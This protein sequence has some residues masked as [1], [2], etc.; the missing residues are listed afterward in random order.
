MAKVLREERQFGLSPIRVSTGNSSDGSLIGRSLASAGNDLA[1]MFFRDAARVAASKGEEGGLSQFAQ[2]IVTIDPDT[3]EPVAYEPPE[4]AGT[5]YTEAYQKVV[6]NRFYK[7][8]DDE[9]KARADELIKKTGGDPAKFN[10]AMSSYVGEMTNVATGP[11]RAYIDEVGKNYN[12]EITKTLV[13]RRIAAERAALKESGKESIV[14]GTNAVAKMAREGFLTVVGLD[15]NDQIS[16]GDTG[17][18]EASLSVVRSVAENI[19]DMTNA[20]LLSEKESQ[21]YM[22]KLQSAYATGVFS[23]A[24]NGITDPLLLRGMKYKI[25]NGIIPEGIDATSE[26]ALNESMASRNSEAILKDIDDIIDNRINLVEYEADLQDRVIAKELENPRTFAD[27]MFATGGNQDTALRVYSTSVRDAASQAFLINN[28]EV[29]KQKLG[30]IAAEIESDVN[31]SIFRILGKLTDDEAEA[32]FQS[33]QTSTPPKG[34]GP[35]F[36]AYTRISE[37]IRGFDGVAGYNFREHFKSAVNT[38]KANG[39]SAT[40]HE[41]EGKET[42]ELAE[43]LGAYT[44]TPESFF[45]AFRWIKGLR[46]DED[47]KAKALKRLYDASFNQALTNLS[48]LK[49]SSDQLNALVVRLNGDTSVQVDERLTA[50]LSDLES[51]LSE[52]GETGVRSMLTSKIT[53]RAEAKAKEESN[54]EIEGRKA[55]ILYAASSGR[56]V[57]D[58]DASKIVEEHLVKIIGGNS[59]M[60]VM[61]ALDRLLSFTNNDG[62]G[63]WSDSEG[64]VWR[65]ESPSDVYNQLV[66]YLGT[67]SV[68]PKSVTDAFK[69]A[70]SLGGNDLI[71]LGKLYEQVALRYDLESNIEVRLP[72][73]EPYAYLQSAVLL[74]RGSGWEAVAQ[75]IPILTGEKSKLVEDAVKEKLN[76][77]SAEEFILATYGKEQAA[78]LYSPIA[79]SLVKTVQLL[80]VN[81]KSEADIKTILGSFFN[82][83]LP[84]GVTSTQDGGVTLNALG[85]DV[86]ANIEAVKELMRIRLGLDKETPII[87]Q[88]IETIKGSMRNPMLTYVYESNDVYTLVPHPRSTVENPTFLIKRVN[89]DSQTIG[90]F[91]DI[92]EGSDIAPHIKP[93]PSLLEKTAAGLT[94][95]GKWWMDQGRKTQDNGSP[96]DSSPEATG[97]PSGPA[98][99][100]SPEATGA[101]NGSPD[102]GSPEATG[103][104]EDG[105]GAPG[106]YD[107]LLYSKWRLYSWK[108]GDWYDKDGNRLDPKNPQD[109]FKIDSIDRRMRRIYSGFIMKNGKWYTKDYGIALDPVEDAETIK[110]A[111]LLQRI[112]RWERR[113]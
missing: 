66:G 91:V 35:V 92:I 94:R 52:A 96:N 22:D 39:A 107:R 77:Q 40:K 3:G 36:E 99:E 78:I 84:D 95:F 67:T 12:N 13:G 30:E 48:S 59:L 51:I 62:N 109:A 60:S 112:K 47:F 10:A 25:A 110:W 72:N 64:N 90:D 106:S 68:L 6:L 49:L 21:G 34:G 113:K 74:A 28:T 27:S 93:T 105:K 46:S 58:E 16:A 82:A 24:L 31:G 26:A 44:Y 76:G 8:Y 14:E 88:S 86:D 38:Y 20:K 63:N 111:Q 37:I 7:S 1:D 42:A 19:T 32:L 102:E 73:M 41:I 5:I 87:L 9:I 29:K 55:S 69:A 71:K 103:V 100:G 80:A 97:V 4:G 33:I 85:N 11:F 83:R 18:I 45:E 75:N 15:E 54:A 56:P 81:G 101:F 61:E 65:G 70:E 57:Y 53:S 98:D 17:R 50:Y 23:Y 108:D 2:D 104:P 79:D 89:V 43:M